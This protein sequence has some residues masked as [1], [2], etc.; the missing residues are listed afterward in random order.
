VNDDHRHK[1]SRSTGGKPD[2]ISDA[3]VPVDVPVTPPPVDRL[4]TARGM[5]KAILLGLPLWAI[6]LA[7]LYWLFH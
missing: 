3:T 4:A 6:L 5:V 7:L 1:G 2:D